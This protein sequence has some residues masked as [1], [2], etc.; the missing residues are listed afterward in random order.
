MKNRL[1]QGS[2]LLKVIENDYCVGCG[3]CAAKEPN[4]IKMNLNEYGQYKPEIANFSNLGEIEKICPFTNDKV[5]ENIL[6]NELYKETENIKHT[7]ETGFY[8]DTFV[9]FIK[10]EE[11]RLASTSGGLISWL[12]QYLLTNNLIDYV[13]C[14]GPSTDANKHFEYQI[15][16]SIEALAKCKKSKYYPVE[17]SAVI[18]KIKKLDGRFLFIGLPCFIKALRKFTRLDPSLNKKIH[19]TIGLICGHL[20]TAKYARYLARHCGVNNESIVNI[21]FRQKVKGNA[22]I[23]YAFKVDYMKNNLLKSGQILMR[24]VW[25]SSWGNN[26]FMLKACEYC[27]DVFSETADITIGDAWLKNYSQDYRG[28]SLVLNRSNAFKKILE[29]GIL[30]KEIQLDPITIDEA[31]ESQSAGLRQRRNGLNARLHML[32]KNQWVPKKR[33]F[34]TQYNYSFVYKIVQFLRIKLCKKSKETFLEQEL[35][36]EGID[37]FIGKLWMYPFILSAINFPKR[38]KRKLISMC[39]I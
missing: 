32:D 26:L 6:A 5:D 31:I 8:L 1:K 28:H 25:G 18:P 33:K 14:V 12:A 7:D 23:N 27:D 2:E 20:K 38:L 21:D 13:V 36:G 22:A 30:K 16:N 37:Y 34:S 17:V 24:D 9:G 35:K 3:M 29:A 39:K 11:K 4:Q 10:N 19:Y 15:I